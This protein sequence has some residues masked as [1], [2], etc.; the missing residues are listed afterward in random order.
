MS[1]ITGTAI[2]EII[3]GV[4]KTPQDSN[5]G[6]QNLD[7]INLLDSQGFAASEYDIQLPNMKNGAIYADS[8]ITDGRTLISAALG[9]VT[10]TIRLELTS[11][12]IIQL[13]ALLSKL[14]QFR[15]DC[16]DYWDSVDQIEPVY[17]KHQVIGEPG[18]RYALIYNI[19][20]NVE[21][22][23]EPNTPQR[24]ITLSIEREYGWRGVKPGGNPKEW[25][26]PNILSLPFNAGNAA[27]DSGTNHL[28]YG[29]VQNTTAWNTTQTAL[30]TQNYIDVPANKVPGDLPAL[31]EYVT[32]LES[33]SGTVSDMLVGV[34]SKPDL[35]SA[36]GATRLPNF[37]LNAGD[38]AVGTDTSLAAD[39]GAPVRSSNGTATRAACTFGTVTTDAIRIQWY[40]SSVG[41]YFDFS[42]LRGKFLCFV[43]A[44]LS[45]ASTVALSVEISDNVGSVI[46]TPV[47]LTDTGS[48]GTGN[49]TYWKAVYMGVVNIP[50]STQP[51]AILDNGKGIE[52]KTTGLTPYL[53]V[54]AERTGS[55]VTLYIADV[56]LIPIDESSFQILGNGYLG[57]GNGFFADNTGYYMHGKA[58][59]FGK[60]TANGTGS[61]NGQITLKP[62]VRNRIMF[63]FFFDSFNTPSHHSDTR[64]TYS[65]RLNLIPRWAG[66]RDA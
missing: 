52:V 47:N 23:I 32:L 39:T 43:R 31:V 46:T 1:N 58:D 26:M 10:E 24:T 5:S 45:A 3:K 42:T 48:G 57:V 60:A 61:V 62:K 37:I 22:P 17:L 29:T 18:P 13:A 19:E 20:I 30:L 21:T 16:I 2:L 59:I 55:A 12:T 7:S 56:I 14:A 35:I 11:S 41:T 9:N 64:N 34:S 4:G 8:P 50:T 28:L 54:R 63:F 40:P 65:V 44:R 33:G 25:T 15:Q 27:L 38:G 66:L 6:E 51:A 53:A 49:T 36:A